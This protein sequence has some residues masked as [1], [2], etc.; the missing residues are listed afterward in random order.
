MSRLTLGPHGGPEDCGEMGP[1][2][3][4]RVSTGDCRRGRPLRR[5]GQQEEGEHG[6]KEKEQDKSDD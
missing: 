1:G 4:A 2:I 5:A 6:G 3:M